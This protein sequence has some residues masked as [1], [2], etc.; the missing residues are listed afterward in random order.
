MEKKFQYELCAVPS[1]L[2]DEY[3]CLRKGIKTPLTKCLGV[4]QPSAP[5]PNI[6]ILNAQQILHHITGPHDG[7]VIVLVD[8]VKS[9]LCK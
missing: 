9:N 2:I 6:I 8:S 7:D 3:G 5:A 1:S 4:M